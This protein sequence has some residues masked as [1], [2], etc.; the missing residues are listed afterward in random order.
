MDPSSR[1][2][3]DLIRGPLARERNGVARMYSSPNGAQAPGGWTSFAF[4]L[5]GKVFSLSST[6]IRGFYAGDGKGYDLHQQTSRSDGWMDAPARHGRGSTPVPGAWQDDE[7]LG[8]FEQ[9]NPN[10]PSVSDVR[11][12]NKR[13]QTDKDSWVMVGT[14]EIADLS[15]KRKPSSNSSIPRSSLASKPAASRAS[16]RRSLA[17]VSRRQSSHVSHTGSPAQHV[18]PPHLQ[19]ASERRASFAP[20]RSPISRPSS[21]RGP[22]TYVS[23][24]AERFV[25]RQA[26]Q[27]KAA[28]KAMSSMSRRLDDLIRQGQQALGTKVSVGGGGG[29][30]DDAMDEGF[31]D[32]EWE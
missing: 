23:P 3:E 5:V 10:S 21:A 25:K 2:E 9:D 14:P 32:E 13:R 26:K 4:G 11:P 28:D 22:G 30:S 7:F 8:D 18:P 16:S 19:M 27:D 1:H 24:E 29:G 6:V 12:S 15:P 31:V 20:I 17:P